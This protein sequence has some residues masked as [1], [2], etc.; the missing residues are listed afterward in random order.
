[1]AHFLNKITT[2]RMLVQQPSYIIKTRAIF[3]V[4]FRIKNIK[5]FTPIFGKKWENTD[6]FN[7][8]QI[9]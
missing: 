3:S 8:P 1:M 5:T 9:S 6:I 7:G 2:N 4:F